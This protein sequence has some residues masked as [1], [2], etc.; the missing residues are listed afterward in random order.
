MTGEA[1][2]QAE[3]IRQAEAFEWTAMHVRRSVSGQK[4]RWMTT[5]SVK[6][7]PDLVLFKPE[8]GILYRELKTD[9]GRITAEQRQVLTDLQAAG[10]NVGIWR[11]RQWPDILATL[12]T[13]TR[14]PL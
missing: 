13:R 1:D 3:V 10:G 7:W 9:R 8:V 2:F 12:R 11:P 6:G 5:T 14:L 4:G